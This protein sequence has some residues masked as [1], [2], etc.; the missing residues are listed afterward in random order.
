[1]TPFPSV[2][3]VSMD[4][5]GAD[6]L[7]VA[8]KATFSIQPR[9]QIAPAQVP[10]ILAD[11][12]FGDPVASS[13][14]YASE[15]MLPKP[16]SDVLFVGSAW[17]PGQKPV[18]ALIAR[19]VFGSTEKS[20]Q[21][22]GERVWSGGA[23]SAP[24]PFVNL[25]VTW[26]NAFGGQHHFAPDKPPAADSCVYVPANPVGKGF[27]GKRKPRE[28]EGLP[29]PN[30]EDPR[31]LLRALGDV[32]TPV[33][34][35]AIAP[36]WES[37]RCFAGTYDEQWVAERAPALPVDF[38]PRYFQTGSPG[39]RFPAQKIIGG[40]TVRL[41]NLSVEADLRFTVPSCPLDLK[42]T[43]KGQSHRLLPQIETLIIE[44][45]ANRFMLVWKAIFPCER[46]ATFIEQISLGFARSQGAAR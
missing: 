38:D 40:E 1:M 43:L 4:A 35:G 2:H 18:P 34:L 23:P 39:L 9:V 42:V 17:A 5:D 29:L 30:I 8:I 26:E 12:Y 41:V 28:L 21:V 31:Q 33:G 46:K 44:P 27:A 22:M 13:L 15:A 16:G 37:R 10:V 32:P 3:L 20:I 11:E 19:L 25:P 14:R 36:A 45:D 24:V 7:L 6:V